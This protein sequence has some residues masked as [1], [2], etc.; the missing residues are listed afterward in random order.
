MVTV[1]T[2]MMMMMMTMSTGV[3][4]RRGLLQA[5][6]SICCYDD[7]GVGGGND[8]DADEDGD[9]ATCIDYHGVIGYTLIAVVAVTATVM[10]IV[11]A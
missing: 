8:G 5:T 9:A 10:R 2:M 6:C 11:K 4:L 7:V 3:K 1:M